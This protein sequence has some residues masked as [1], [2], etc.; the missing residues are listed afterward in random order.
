MV[1]TALRYAPLCITL[2]LFA[3]VVTWIVSLPPPWMANMSATERAQAV[4]MQRLNEEDRKRKEWWVE[5]VRDGDA[6]FAEA[7][8]EYEHNGDWNSDSDRCDNP[9]R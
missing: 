5:E 7:A 3:A 8:C 4:Q 9:R 2:G 6:S 1:R